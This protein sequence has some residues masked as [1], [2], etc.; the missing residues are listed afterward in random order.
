M[1]KRMDDKTLAKFIHKPRSINPKSKMPRFSPKIDNRVDRIKNIVLYLRYLETI[2]N[3][4]RETSTK[5]L[6]KVIDGKVN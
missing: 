6:F 3:K 5:K 2:K 1:T 4:E